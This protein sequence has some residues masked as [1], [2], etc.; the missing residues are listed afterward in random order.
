MDPASP[1][2]KRDIADS[3]FYYAARAAQNERVKICIATPEMR[4]AGWKYVHQ[5]QLVLDGTF[6]VCTSR[7]L[8]WI[9]MGVDEAHHGIP[10]AMFLFSA[11]SGNRATH[12]G[13]DTEILAELLGEWKK[14]MGCS[15]DEAKRPFEPFVA[16]TDTDTKERGALLRIWPDIILLLCKFHVRQ[17]WKN[18]RSTLFNKQVTHW[19][20][21]LESRAQNLEE[22]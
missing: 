18:K 1:H 7:L 8:L 9:A 6:G 4:T 15:P 10:V 22:L 19:K 14:W 11:P 3:V 2:F 21:Y 5:Q 13:Y 16:M 20:S 12:A 17:C